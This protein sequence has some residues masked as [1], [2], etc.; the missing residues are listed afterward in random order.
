MLMATKFVPL[1]VTVEGVE[2]VAG[3]RFVAG[4]VRAGNSRKVG[5]EAEA[6]KSRKQKAESRNRRTEDGGRRDGKC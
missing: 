5:W 1:V 6:F 3:A 2:G 4:W